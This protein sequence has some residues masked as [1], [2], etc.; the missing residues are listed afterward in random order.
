M[1][2]LHTVYKQIRA[3]GIRL[4]RRPMQILFHLLPARCLISF[5]WPGQSPSAASARHT[6]S[7]AMVALHASLAQCIL[8]SGSRAFLQTCGCCSPQRRSTSR[9]ACSNRMLAVFGVISCM[10]VA[11]LRSYQDRSMAV[12]RIDCCG[13]HM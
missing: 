4:T 11:C 6:G 7:P 9:Q 5:C 10:R 13:I 12:R 8:R 2:F 1:Y 3:S